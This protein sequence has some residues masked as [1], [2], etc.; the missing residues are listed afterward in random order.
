MIFVGFVFHKVK[1]TLSGATFKTRKPDFQNVYPTFKTG[2][3]PSFAIRPGKA[4]L[5]THFLA[6]E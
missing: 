4:I 5:P 1:C 6:A 3:S 2:K